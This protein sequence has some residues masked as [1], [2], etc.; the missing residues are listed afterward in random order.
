MKDS[1]KIK[2]NFLFKKVYSQGRYYAESCL[3]LYV[4]KNDEDINKVGFSVSK[5]IGKSVKR[6]RVKRLMRENYRQLS[7]KIKKGYLMVFAARKKSSEAD[8]YDIQ[9]EMIN[10]LRRARLLKEDV[11]K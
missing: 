5:T 7:D 1:E 10:A 9:R 2:K 3:V 8:Y 6:N 4:L 11:K